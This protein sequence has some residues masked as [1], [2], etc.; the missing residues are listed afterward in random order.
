MLLLL[1]SNSA[2][3]LADAAPPAEFFG[4]SDDVSWKAS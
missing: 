3:I 2:K 1:R 4:R